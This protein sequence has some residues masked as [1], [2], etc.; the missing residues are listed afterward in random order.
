MQFLVVVNRIRILDFDSL[1]V[2]F[3]NE[4]FHNFVV[5]KK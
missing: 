3:F 2:E 5:E 1:L 4:D